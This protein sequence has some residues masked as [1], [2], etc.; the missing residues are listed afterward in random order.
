MRTERDHRLA[1]HGWPTLGTMGSTRGSV[2]LL[3]LLLCCW[4]VLLTGAQT[5]K[6]NVPRLKLSYK[7]EYLDTFTPRLTDF[8]GGC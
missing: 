5:A 1:R 2:L 4:L 3:L 7:G 8:F 6:S